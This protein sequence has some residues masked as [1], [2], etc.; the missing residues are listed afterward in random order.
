MS[1]ELGARKIS[2]AGTPYNSYPVGSYFFSNDPTDPH[3]ILGFGTWELVI[4][5]QTSD[6]I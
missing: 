4:V 5:T 6:P 2:F 1:Q 3:A